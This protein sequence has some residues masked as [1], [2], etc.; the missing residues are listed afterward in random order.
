MKY[1]AYGSNCS[2]AIMKKKG[3]EFTGRQRAELRGYRLKFN[4]KS[5]R[6]ALPDTVGFANI[7]EDSAGVVEGILYEIEDTSLG[8][9]DESERYPDHYDRVVV[10][11]KTT[12]G[13]VEC[14]AYK[15]Q[16]DKLA[17]GLVPSRNYLN[18]ILAARDFLSDQYFQALDKSQTYTGKCACCHETS[19][20]VFIRENDSMSTLC[21]PCRE[22]L[23][24]WG[25][26]RGRRLTVP[27]T[28]AVMMGLVKDGAGFPSIAALVQEAIATKLIDP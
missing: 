8:L 24:V 11:V 1:F 3:V 21:Q 25:D 26:V 27:E 6:A 10:E 16:P 14:C 13:N 20:V 7:N 17:A 15:A 28:E 22:A 12:Q 18:H 9:L 19:E 2:P 5:L 23:I 4:K